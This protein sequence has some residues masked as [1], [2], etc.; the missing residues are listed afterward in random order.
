MD[1]EEARKPTEG[2]LAEVEEMM[3]RIREGLGDEDVSPSVADLLRLMELRRDLAQSG[4]RPVTVRWIDEC[5]PTP[6]CGE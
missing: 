6:V 1:Q 5:Q 4:P 2:E 3:Q